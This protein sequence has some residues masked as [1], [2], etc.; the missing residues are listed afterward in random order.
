MQIQYGERGGHDIEKGTKILTA[1]CS[2]D[3]EGSSEQSW[4]GQCLEDSGE[5]CLMEG[6][7]T[8]FDF[9]MGGENMKKE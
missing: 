7:K 2:G 6:E 4:P 1:L 5:F 8:R 3:D 9:F